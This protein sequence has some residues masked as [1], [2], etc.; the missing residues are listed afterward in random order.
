[1]I[2][3]FRDQRPFDGSPGLIAVFRALRR[4]LAPRHPPHALSSL[5]ALILSS[6]RHRRADR[7][8]LLAH[9]YAVGSNDDPLL[10]LRAHAESR[11][12][13]QR[14]A[15]HPGLRFG[16]VHHDEIL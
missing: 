7:F 8:Q 5:A 6:V 4:L 15:R 10:S 3:E 11:K 2:R 14:E 9:H 12:K 1:M 16:L 13:L